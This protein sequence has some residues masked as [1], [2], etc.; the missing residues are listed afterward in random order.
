MQ[1]KAQDKFQRTFSHGRKRC[2]GGWSTTSSTARPSWVAPCPSLEL[3]TT[4]WRRARPC[5]GF[6]AVSA[7][8]RQRAFVIKGFYTCI[9]EQFT[10][11][12]T[13]TCYQQSEWNADNF[14]GKTSAERSWEAPTRR[15]LVPRPFDTS[16]SWVG[17]GWA[18]RTQHWEHLG[19]DSASPFE[20]L[21]KRSNRLG[22]PSGLNCFGRAMARPS[23]WDRDPPMPRGARAA[24][25]FHF[26]TGT[27]TLS[28]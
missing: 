2:I 15:P 20:A 21:A 26:R 5:S 13:A 16:C 27:I 22:V 6:A 7:A 28:T 17:R 1:Q 9:R 25:L 8:E 3:S 18:C 11:P 12:D 10:E 14:I 24:R 19:H 23:L 4:S